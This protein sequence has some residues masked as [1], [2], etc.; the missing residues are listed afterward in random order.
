MRTRTQR[1]SG[2]LGVLLALQS[3]APS[4]AGGPPVAVSARPGVD[5]MLLRRVRE[6]VASRRPVRED[7][8]LPAAG[9]VSTER[10]A[11][12]QRIAAIRLALERSRKYES[13]A[14]WDDCVR[15]AA[16]AMSDAIDV[17]AASGEPG[18]LRDLHMQLGVCASLAASAAN[19]RPHF[20][21]AALLDESPPPAGVHREEAERAAA[22]ARAEILART[23]GRVRI[24]TEPP[25]AE[26][27]I[28][29]RLVAGT[30]PLDVDVRLGDHF[31]TARRFR[32]EPHTELRVLQPSGAVRLVL[33]PARRATLRDQLAAL[34][35]PDA[36]RP[37][38]DEIRLAR[39]VWSRAEQVLLV[40]SSTGGVRVQLL[41]AGSGSSL[42]SSS[43]PRTDEDPL[44]RAVCNA[45]GESC[46]P[47][48]RGIPW[49]VWPLAGAVVVG[50]VVTTALIVSNERDTTFCP[51]S[52]C[53]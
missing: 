35:R 39:A 29:G 48:S 38:D 10:A 5:A 2:P 22:E 1:W 16:S 19:A 47:V 24:E 6:V 45:L 37:P 50:G 34:G 23:R 51:P 36:N 42:R 30:T 49:Y 53:R 15:E 31:V 3:S 9:S 32:F 33:D 14:A 44:R 13:E 11:A 43:A 28:D 12:E 40:S 8:P 20:L 52:G 7:L 27:W 25:G 46:E 21:S 4:W 26:I 17:I 41:D 18:L